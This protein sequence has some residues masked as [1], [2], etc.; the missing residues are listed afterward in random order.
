L[1]NKPFGLRCA[2]SEVAEIEVVHMNP[3]SIGA[4]ESRTHQPLR[5]DL[6]HYGLAVLSVSAALGTSLLLQYFHFR[7]ASVPL[8]LFAVAISSWYGGPGPAV[9]SVILS[10]ISFYWYFVEPVR[11]IYIYPSEI[12]YFVIFAGFAT[13]ISSFSK[14][15]RRAEEALHEKADL[16]DLTHDTVFVMDMDGVIKYWNRGAEERYEWTAEQAVGRNVHDLLK[17]V[18]PGPSEQ[19]KAEVIRTG[20]WEGEL[21]HTKKD[22]TQVVAAS[23]WSLQ[24]SKQGAP[25]AI[26]ETNNDITERKRA[27]EALRRL[28]RELRALS[29]CNQT[30]LR[31]TDEQSL[32]AEICRIVCEEAGYRV[33]WVGYA[34]Y[35][36]AKS[37]RPVAWTAAEE[38]S[39]ASAGVTWADTERGRGPTGTAIR[40]GKTCCIR[41]YAT[42]PRVAPWRENA[43]LRDFRSAIALPLKDEQANAFGTLNIYSA[44]PDA[45]APEETRLLEE[46][47]ADLAFGVVTLRSRAARKQAEE[48]LR[49]S[50]ANLT[51]AQEIA[52]IGSW[53]RDFARNLL[54][55]SDEVYRIFG[56]P[57]RT[58]LSY[59]AFLEMVHPG[60]RES[61][62]NAWSAALHGTPYDIEH[63]I[64]VGGDLKW[65]RERAQVEF[66]KDGKATRGIGTV[67]DITERKRAEE[68][69]RHLNRELCAIS[70]C[71]Q[72]LLRAMDE[73]SLLQEICR[74][75][76]DDAGYEV[77]WVGYA[78]HD[79][80]KSVRPV[81]W[82]G[83]EL[84]DV[85][86]LGVTWAD[87]ESGRGPGGTAIRTGKTCWIKDYATDPEVALWKENAF[88]HGFRSA[89]GLPLKDESG[90]PFGSL[91]IYSAQ[92]NAFTPEE[93]RLLE[94]LAADMAFGI[95]NLRSRAA[96]E[97]AEQALRQS[98]AYLAE[99]Q[100]LTHTGSWALDLDTAKYVYVSEEDF[101]IWGLDPHQGLPTR[102]AVFQRIHPEDR[103]QV[104]ASL[105]RSL[106]GGVDSSDEYRIVLPEGPFKQIHTIRHPVL[107]SAG[108][109]VKLFGTSVDITERKQAEEALRES[110][111]RFRT[112]VDHAA[113]A[114]FIYDF[115]SG[116]IVDV[117]RQ[118]CE[119]L[120]YSRQEM[121]GMSPLAFHLDSDGANME[122]VMQR[123]STGETVTDRHSHRRKDGTL[124]P[125]EAHTSQ[126]CYGGRRFLLK[127]ARDISDRVRAEEALR[128]SERKY[129]ELVEH[130]N[131]IILHWQRD[132]RIIF[133]NEFGQSFFGY[134]ESE[135]RGRHVIGTIVPETE[136]SGRDLE[137]LI[138]E[139]CANPSAFEQNINEN[140]RRNGE[141]VWIAWTNKVLLNSKGEVAEILSVGADI[142][143]RKRMEEEL[144][145]MQFSLEHASD[146]IYWM[147]SQGHIVF[148]NEAACRSLG[149]SQ[150]EVLSLSIPDI[151]PS[152]S[153][154]LWASSWKKLKAGGSITLETFHRNKHGRVFPVEVTSNYLDFGGKEYAFAFARDITERKGAEE[155]LRESE[156]RFRTFVDHA[157]DAFFVHDE[158]NQR[159]IVDVNRQACESLGYTREELI[160][161][162]PHE[163]DPHADAL[164]L[165]WISGRLDAG[166]ACTFETR[167]QRKDGTL[168][169]VEVRVRSFRHGGRRLNLALARDITERKLAEEALRRSEA[170][171][172]EGQRLTHTGS[173]AWSAATRRS[174]YWS[175]EMLRMYG[176]NPQEGP[177]ATEAFWQRIHPE[178]LDGVRELLLKVADRHTE[179][180]HDHRIILPDGTV[181]HIHA[182][183]HPVLN[184]NGQ[185]TEYVGTAIDVTE[186]KRAEQERERLRQL[187]ADLAH[188]NRVSLLGEL[189]A[190]IA[191]EINQPIS[192]VVSNGSACLR[193]LAR[194][195][196]DVEEACEAARR[197]VRD[198]KR[199]GEVIARIRALTRRA[200]TPREKLDLNETILDVLALIGDE[201]KRKRVTIRTQF[202]DELS[203]V[204]GDR[205]Q[206]QQ[207]LL[208]LFMN[209][210]EAMSSVEERPRELLISTR[211]IGAGEVQVTVKDS[212]P[213]IDP[214][215]LDKIFDPFYTTKPHGMGMGLSIC[216]SI[217]QAHGGR[218][219][220]A[221][222]DGPGTIFHFSLPKYE[223]E[224]PHAAI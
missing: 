157:T 115:E 58:A 185:V 76:C 178:D 63:R 86:E 196:P 73:Q 162:E 48:A 103:K 67:Q 189:A 12:P 180:E 194:D 59:K 72:A 164:L 183:G 36:E 133:L 51:R 80:A 224:E 123:A 184:N 112:F 132:G 37:V 124:F 94:E 177:P 170:Y 45:F 13:L 205:V 126:F 182:I 176:F 71:N 41:D 158:D 175:E 87:M 221:A 77:A 75:V 44:Q 102:E 192:G 1:E 34:E 35:D 223:E 127:V 142:T 209:A 52:H 135:I 165:E 134:T 213:G 136:S 197:I 147:D 17:T 66:S 163:F 131:S 6:Q 23:R 93:I 57:I 55:W 116:I 84:G 128:E 207:V 20:R 27:E 172:A 107:N 82:V 3:P 53:H 167:H 169:P 49:E 83:V 18:F 199:A 56:V 216:R 145:L 11:T 143:A 39:V 217:L 60:D 65:V 101:R 64:V 104:E 122:S 202:V 220:A 168:F 222:K 5:T 108:D 206:L 81:A 15:R 210:I 214:N 149:R 26:L 33:A 181:K 31:A 7:D 144:R 79:E 91:I 152:F 114:L 46:L 146:A 92:P 111:S 38:A 186:Q 29:N 154:E 113:D 140:M 173:F 95:V 121:I 16:L 110:E 218:L 151:D 106:R 212:G 150:A 174:L 68:G 161:M 153:A 8:L 160:G 10:I 201:A 90:N 148:V 61:V 50:E 74:I 200:A 191:H 171:L 139:I 97:R 159:R 85:A 30:L 190:S 204:S 47:A 208:N 179:Y 155:S 195:V 211:N 99:S 137:K 70:N 129:H 119:S 120:G 69:L 78:E 43:V 100:R 193:W 198:G 219:W 62:D 32:L 28:N 54:I 117:N 42:D 88:Q 22:G 25:V 24:R 215:T 96:R 141:H 138:E 166:E 125:V 14:I 98:E 89:I 188:I 40:S 2:E 187:E 21:L 19:I 9:M 105:E 156:T 4:T 118:A 130:A 109:V 203:P